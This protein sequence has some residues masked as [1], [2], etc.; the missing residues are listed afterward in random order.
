MHF[1]DSRLRVMN[2]LFVENLTVI[3][4][5]YLDPHRGLLGESW[6]VD[7]T[8]TGELDDQGMVFDF[9]NVKRAIKA[10]IDE[11][12]DHRLLIPIQAPNLSHGCRDGRI[13]LNWQLQDGRKISY[14]SPG[15]AVVLVAA[16]SI[17]PSVVSDLLSRRLRAV[18]PAN[19]R[20]VGIELRE[21]S[22]DGPSY[23][24]VHGLKKHLGN[25][26]RLAHGHRSRL[27]IFRDGRRDS[28]LEREWAQRFRDSFIGTREDLRARSVE[29]GRDYLHFAYEAEQGDFQLKLPA[30]SVYL[31]DTDTTVEWIATHLADACKSRFPQSHIRVRAFEGVG[32]GALADR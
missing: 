20:E 22:I 25:C 15:Q 30:A 10:L 16:D 3:D 29:G 18:L 1:A 17:C 8:L 11:E 28:M 32:K 24:Y 14:G 26:Q 9:G 6:I 27:Q 12:V 4:F 21:E 13:D 23:H 31:M 5:A 19:V 2:G 7:L